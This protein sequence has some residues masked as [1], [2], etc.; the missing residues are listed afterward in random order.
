A[1]IGSGDGLVVES[2]ICPRRISALCSNKY[3]LRSSLMSF[4][5]LITGTSSGIGRLAAETVARAGH[6]VYATMRD[7]TTRNAGAADSLAKLAAEQT[8]PLK[9]L[10]MDV[11]NSDSVQ[12]AVDTVLQEQGRLDVAVNNA[13]I[14]S[15]GLAEGFTEEQML[16]QMNVNFMGSFRVSRAVLP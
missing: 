4:V 6:S 8:L 5:V 1:R 9:V 13:G 15:I 3:K 14:M 11:C 2:I 16:H 7:L 10:E 12:R